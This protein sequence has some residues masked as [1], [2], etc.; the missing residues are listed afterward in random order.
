M[1][2]QPFDTASV[3]GILG[4]VHP[5]FCQLVDYSKYELRD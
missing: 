2:S 5:A 3:G 1:N 4:P